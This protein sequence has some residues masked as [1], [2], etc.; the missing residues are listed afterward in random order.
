MKALRSHA[1]GGPESLTL[2]ELESPVPGPG[3]VR[4]KVKA[5]SINYPDV[6]II[7]DMYQFKPARPF[8]PGG[9]LAGVVDAV[10]EIADSARVWSP[11]DV[12]RLY[13]VWLKTGSPRAQ[14]LL[15]Q[16]SHHVLRKAM[17]QAS[18]VVAPLI[19]SVRSV[20]RAMASAPPPGG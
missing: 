9:E 12:L 16:W 5:C 18:V 15:R 17:Q 7:K 8:A 2:D 14:A 4:I 1:I 13:E 6:L 11:K 10:G 20:R 3:Q 19:A